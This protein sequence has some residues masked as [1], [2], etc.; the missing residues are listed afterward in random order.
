MLAQLPILGHTLPSDCYRC[1]HKLIFPT[2][3]SKLKR[4]V[5]SGDAQITS[6]RIG[7]GGFEGLKRIVI[8]VPLIIRLSIV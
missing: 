3:N 2:S 6:N 7:A 8:E 1:T 4:I 5:N